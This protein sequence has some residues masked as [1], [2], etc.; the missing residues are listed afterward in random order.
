MT[1]D[2]AMVAALQPFHFL[3]RRSI[4]LRLGSLEYRTK[5]CNNNTP[6]KIG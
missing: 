5:Q 4:R 3:L 2:E 6:N 1:P